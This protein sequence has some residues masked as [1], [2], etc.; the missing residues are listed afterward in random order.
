MVNLKF[1][2]LILILTFLWNQI[3]IKLENLLFTYQIFTSSKFKN[4]LFQ[5]KK[6][7]TTN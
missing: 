5:K 6:L 7:I 4:G 3:G 1:S 2:K